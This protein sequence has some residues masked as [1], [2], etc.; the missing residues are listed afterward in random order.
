MMLLTKF[1]AKMCFILKEKLQFIKQRTVMVGAIYA[2]A[3]WDV[4]QRS[5]VIGYRRFGGPIFKA[6]VTPVAN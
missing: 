5:L 2:F 4:T 3:F 1:L 6:L